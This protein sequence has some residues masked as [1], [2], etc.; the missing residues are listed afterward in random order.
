M[1]KK[2]HVRVIFFLWSTDYSVR[3]C[4]VLVDRNGMNLLRVYREGGGAVP[5]DDD[6]L[7]LDGW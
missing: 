3:K 6:S 5:V 1:I 7:Q 4:V 2:W